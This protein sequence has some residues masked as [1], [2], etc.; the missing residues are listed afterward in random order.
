MRLSWVWE[1]AGRNKLTLL[2]PCSTQRCQGPAG[3]N[4]GGWVGGAA[5]GNVLLGPQGNSRRRQEARDRKQ[6][7][8]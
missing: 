6:G 1:R 7:A 8:S 5:L 3:A 2:S 4:C